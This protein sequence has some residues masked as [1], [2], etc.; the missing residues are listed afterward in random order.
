[1][2]YPDPS[3]SSWDQ[4]EQVEE[5]PVVPAHVEAPAYSHEYYVCMLA[6]AE[7]H[8]SLTPIRRVRRI[9]SQVQLGRQFPAMPPTIRSLTR[10]LN[11]S[12]ISLPQRT[13]PT[14][15]RSFS[16][17][18]NP[19]SPQPSPIITDS[20][21][22]LHTRRPAVRLK[23]LS[24]SHSRCC[25]RCNPSSHSTSPPAVHSKHPITAI[26]CTFDNPAMCYMLCFA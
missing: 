3:A 20:P 12:R 23:R 6:T 4:Y 24:L 8:L 16:T 18:H 10:N 5:T 1:M 26:P 13:A 2:S 11:T 14:T 15:M 7:A 22:M 19:C 17:S 25:H 9:Q 21:R